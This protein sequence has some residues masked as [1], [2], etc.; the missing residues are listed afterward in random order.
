M[1]E[2]IKLLIFKG[3]SYDGCFWEWNA[4]VFEDGA[5][6]KPLVSGRYGKQ[7]VSAVSRLG[8][9]RGVREITR[10]QY[11]GAD[12]FFIRNERQW[13]DFC[14]QFNS[15]FV[16]N[17]ANHAG[18]EVRCDACGKFFPPEEI[19]HTGYRGDGGVG[20]SYCDNKCR[21]CADSEHYD[22]IRREWPSLRLKT[23]VEAIQKARREG[24]D[25][26]VLAARRDEM[27]SIP[28]ECV[29]EPEYY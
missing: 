9:F 19:V 21:E 8:T 22:Y 24:Y 26:S 2:N 7:A 11:H 16:R 4:L 25:V 17:V 10:E 1:S 5:L 18:K 15:G 20:I 3:G 6:V 27:P 14:K 13:E 23:R 28:A 12:A 29:Y